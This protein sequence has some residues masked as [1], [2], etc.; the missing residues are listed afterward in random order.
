MILANDLTLDQEKQVLDLLREN[1]EALGWT[2]GGIRGISPTIV[3]HCIHFED[4]VKPYWDR[5]RRLNPTL[6]EVVR[7]E[8][9]KWLNHDIIYLISDSEWVSPVHV[10]PRKTG[11]TVVKNDRDEL[12]PTRIQSGWRVCIDYRK[13]NSATKKDHFPLPFLDQMLERLSGRAY[14]CFLNGYSGYTQVHIAP[15]D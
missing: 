4:N 12:I 1:Q 11:I 6:Q 14:Y 13:L 15:E 10:V 3:Q 7:K 9:L 5:Q 2:L 8:V